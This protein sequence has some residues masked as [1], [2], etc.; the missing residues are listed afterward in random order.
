MKKLTFFILLI[1]IVM[2]IGSYTVLADEI[3]YEDYT[4]EDYIEEPVIERAKVLTVEEFQDPDLGNDFF[5]E[6]MLVTLEILSGEYKGQQFQSI[7]SLTGN[8]TYDIIVE[9]GDTVLVAIEDFGD[10]SLEIYISEYA[11]DRYIYM[12]LAVFGILVILI[13]GFKG[14]KT[15]I[16]LILTIGLILKVLLPGLLAG[17][18]PIL[19][20]IA[21]SFLVTVVT[22][23]LVGGTN[24]KSYAAIIGVLGGVFIA[25]ILAYVVGTQV[26]L[27]G[28]S[29]QEATMLMYIPQGVNFD[30]RGLL[31]AGIIMGALGA[32]MDV[33]MSIA[34]SMEEIRNANPT[35]SSKALI[36]SGMNVGKDIMGTMANT[37]ILAYTGSAIPL[38]LLFTAYQDPLVRIINLDIIATEIVRAFTGSIGLILCIPL[39][40]VVYVILTEKS[41]RKEVTKREGVS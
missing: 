19:L 12:I 15:I 23:L 35:M 18:N 39:T 34:S 32:V 3:Y 6:N 29:S 11:R 41:R 5:I 1:M 33:G 14:V 28:L 26:R 4:H 24:R 13:G 16:T 7:H 36:M 22:I 17:Y 30:F 8:F 27:T 20:T 31:F 2:T 10:G 25:G 40:A 9:P 37:L 21:I 38:L